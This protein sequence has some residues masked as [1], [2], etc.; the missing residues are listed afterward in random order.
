MPGW[1]LAVGRSDV[2]RIEVHKR[3]PGS[4]NL[5]LASSRQLTLWGE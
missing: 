4:D 5:L 1:S 2:A 3:E